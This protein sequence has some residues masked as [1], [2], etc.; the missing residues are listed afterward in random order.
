MMLLKEIFIL[1]I[2]AAAT[3][4]KFEEFDDIEDAIVND[5]ADAKVKLKALVDK[6]NKL[7]LIAVDEHH[8]LHGENNDH[9]EYHNP[10]FHID[11]EDISIFEIYQLIL[12]KMITILQQD[13]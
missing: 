6:V 9:D 12:K 4:T 10:L 7:G 1:L 13:Y 11:E 2:S 3:D 5:D 8:E